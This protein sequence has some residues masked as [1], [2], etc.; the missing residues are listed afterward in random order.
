MLMLFR[1]VL[2]G[3]LKKIGPGLRC[4]STISSKL[5]WQVERNQTFSLGKYHQLGTVFSQLC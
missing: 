2:V 5:T 3:D 4:L 1:G